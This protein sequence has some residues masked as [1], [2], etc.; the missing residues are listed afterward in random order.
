MEILLHSANV[1][2]LV[3]Y[4]MRDILWLRFFTIIAA[5]CLIFY[6]YFLPEPLLTPVYW[7]VLFIYLNVFWV[8]R[9]LLERRP[10]QLTADEQQLC[11]LVFRLVSPREMINL[12]KIGTWQTAAVD[13]CIAPAGEQLDRLMLIH[14]G[15][16][17]YVVNGKKTQIFG[18]GQ[19][20]GS[21]SFVTDETAPA[22]IVVLEPTRYV[23]WKKSSLRK[24][25]SKNPE[26]H[27]AIQATLGIDLSKK[28]EA[29]WLQGQSPG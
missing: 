11:D 20:M 6:F 21:I 9:L 25:L 16:V 7:N 23:C 18:P 10:V 12:L 8:T 28:L 26:L 17:C 4:V 1:I 19:F 14:S 22:D 5:V 24:Y 2:Y 13:D 27:A 15:Q 29:S 3:S